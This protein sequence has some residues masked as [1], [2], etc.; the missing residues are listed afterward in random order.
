MEK[1]DV[2]FESPEGKALLRSLHV[3]SYELFRR[4]YKQE[5]NERGKSF[6]D[7]VYDAIVKAPP[8]TVAIINVV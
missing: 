6:S 4:V 1:G 5:V 2:N 7:Y 8:K 3:Y